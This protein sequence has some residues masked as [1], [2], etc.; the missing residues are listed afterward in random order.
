M[1]PGTR[2]KLAILF[3]LVYVS[4]DAYSL[5]YPA[6]GRW[7]L[8]I[9]PWFLRLPLTSRGFEYSLVHWAVSHRPIHLLLRAV[10]NNGFTGTMVATF[11]YLLWTDVGGAR[12]LVRLYALTFGIL[13]VSFVLFHTY[14]PHV[15]YSLPERYAPNTAL[16][17]P[18]FVF[19]SPHCSIAFVSL[20]AVWRKKGPLAAS[21]KGFLV[22]VPISTVLLGE[23]WVWDVIGGFGV[24]LAAA[25]VEKR[26]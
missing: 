25:A 17:R 19:P 5:V 21:L 1:R 26:V 13:A 3:V 20:I 24:A 11:L 15:I 8:N 4:W 6:I 9:T 16:T 14:A 2:A 22:L 7:S 18:Q 10:Y 12:R 23:H